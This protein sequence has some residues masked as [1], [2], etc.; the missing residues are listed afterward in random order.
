MQDSIKAL[1][2]T[3][4]LEELELNLFRG[5]QPHEKRQR[6]FGGQVAGQ[7][8]VAACRTVEERA[9]HSLHAY[10][11][12]PGDPS[13]P[14]IYE[15][16]R[17]RDGRSFTTRRVTAIQ[18]GRPI[19]TLSASFHIEEESFDHQ[20]SMP[21]V[22][23]PESLPDWQRR[24]CEEIEARDDIDQETRD[25]AQRDR[26]IETR[27]VEFLDY[28]GGRQ[29]P[30]AHIWMR[31]SGR[32]PDDPLL[33]QCIVAY[34]SD[35]TL[36]DTAARPHP[37]PLLRSNTVMASLD[38]AM[39]FHRPLRADEWLLYAQQSPSM[40]GSRGFTMGHFYQRDG[41]LVASVVQE[42]LFRLAKP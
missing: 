18:H 40:S 20:R 3:L 42:G 34:A 25:W 29:E 23:D 8:L 12:R 32:L 39:W 21:E 16:E 14:I 9:V 27:H 22:P 13:I 30:I 19:F 36:L 4:D 7:A 11:L 41:A 6:V 35:M 33:H 17:T 24:L 26:A 2:E 37:I 5:T 10:F 15:V 31:A 28:F 1:L 38:H